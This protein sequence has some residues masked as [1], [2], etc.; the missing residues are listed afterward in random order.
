MRFRPI[1]LTVALFL[2]L[3]GTAFADGG[4]ILGTA[5]VEGQPA[6]D[7]CVD[8]QDGANTVAS[9]KTN[10]AGDYNLY[11][12]TPGWYTVQFSDCGVG[13]TSTQAS[14]VEVIGDQDSPG[15]DAHLSS[16]GRVAGNLKDNLAAVLT[17]ACVR[18]EDQNGNPVGETTTDGNGD[19]VVGGLPPGQTKLRFE[20]CSAGNY[21]PGTESVE[22]EAGQT[23]SGIDALLIQAGKIVGHLQNA[24]GEP[25]PGICV[26][27]WVGDTELSGAVTNSNG[28]YEIR[29][30]PPTGNYDLGAWDCYG[31]TY[32]GV[33]KT[34]PVAG[35][36]TATVD[37]V[38]PRPG[39]ITGHV[40]DDA[41]AGL[42]SICVTATNA[43]DGD[44]AVALTD[45]NGYYELNQL[46]P[47]TWDLTFNAAIAEGEESACIA[48]G[49]WVPATTMGVVLPD[50][51]TLWD[52]DKVL[53]HAPAAP[54]AGAGSGDGGARGGS[55]SGGGGE[56]AAGGTGGSG[57]EASGAGGSGPV[58]SGGHPRGCKVPKLVGL[59]LAKAK[60][61]LAKAGCRLGRVSRKAGR[62]HGRVVRQKIRRGAAKPAGFKV[63]L[64]VAK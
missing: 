39:F 56:P 5:Y 9:Q 45:R 28:D 7:I 33:N 42:A 64:T 52:V 34:G 17:G 11:I 44:K 55:G 29:G 24:A 31:S 58:G 51:E 37:F 15:V 32:M 36:G 18:A 53:S 8:V 10:Q 57:A 35:T 16:A 30:V 25:L 23:T 47:G 59:S 13:Y 3:H 2:L 49:D 43:A 1:F 4:N 20:G 60:K 19:Y 6:A 40:R 54:R 27:G 21:V 61:A 48:S 46:R 38:L 50:G 63:A 22:V 41:G 12:A 62:R 26:S 14:S